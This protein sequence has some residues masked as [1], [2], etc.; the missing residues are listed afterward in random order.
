MKCTISVNNLYLLEAKPVFFTSVS[1]DLPIPSILRVEH[2]IRYFL[3]NEMVSIEID[4]Y[5]HLFFGSAVIQ[6]ICKIAHLYVILF[7]EFY[8][9]TQQELLGTADITD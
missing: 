4:M 7:W 6:T 1:Q 8:C 5:Q 2:G 9:F 3:Q